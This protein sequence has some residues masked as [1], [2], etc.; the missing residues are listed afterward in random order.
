MY[1]LYRQYSWEESS[2]SNSHSTALAETQRNLPH[3]LPIYGIIEMNKV[4]ICAHIKELPDFLQLVD[5][6][7]ESRQR[8]RTDLLKSMDSRIQ[9]YGMVGV[10]SRTP[11]HINSDAVT[12]RRSAYL[13][14]SV[15]SVLSM[16]DQNS[17]TSL[18]GSAESSTGIPGGLEDRVRELAHDNRCH[19]GSDQS[20]H[21][22][23]IRSL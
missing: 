1:S 7:H 13:T 9:N 8:C 6:T 17:K 20:A 2:E 12:Y 14:S 15:N 19:L 21:V 10:G 11:F 18:Q 23:K 22:K 4:K 16:G 5:A 3:G